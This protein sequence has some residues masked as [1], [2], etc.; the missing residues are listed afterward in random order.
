MGPGQRALCVPTDKTCRIGL[1]AGSTG[2]G[3]RPHAAKGSGH[4]QYGVGET[5]HILKISFTYF[6]SI[7]SHVNIN[8]PM[9]PYNRLARTSWVISYACSVHLLVTNF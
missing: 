7:F 2:P 1:E 4:F 9:F 6:T 8:V 3:S 5:K